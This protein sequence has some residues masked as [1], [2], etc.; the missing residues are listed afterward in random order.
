MRLW[1]IVWSIAYFAIRLA[2]EGAGAPQAAVAI[3]DVVF[4]L[5]I[6]YSLASDVEKTAAELGNT[7]LINVLIVSWAAAIPQAVVAAALAAA[8]R[9]EA[10][11]YD[12]MVSTLVDAFLVTAVVRLPFLQRLREEWWLIAVWVAATLTYGATIAAFYGTAWAFPYHVAWFI[13]GAALLPALFAGR[14]IAAKIRPEPYTVVNAIISAASL[15]YISWELGWA[16]AGWHL[17]SEAALG[18]I[19]AVFATVPDLV[20]AFLI[21]TTLARYISEGAGAED[22]IRTM[23][24]AAVHDQISVPA[25]VVLLFPDAVWAFPHWLNVFVSVLKFTLLDRRAFLGLGL[26]AA[27]AAIVALLAGLA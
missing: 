1:P 15:G 24:A 13:V 25:L 12:S 11:F 7:R 8:G 21:R 20:T 9:Y 5:G 14:E 19:A 10:A 2:A 3:T 22:A 26:P 16:L 27:V 17:S 18:A 4:L 6:L 23:F